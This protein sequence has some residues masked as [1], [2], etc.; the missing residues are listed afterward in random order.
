[1]KTLIGAAVIAGALVF[2]GPAAINSAVAA[3]PQTR[4]QTAGTSGATDFSAQR[5][6]RRTYGYGYRP[7]VRPYDPPT[8]YARPSYYRPYPYNVSAPFPLGL[9]FGPYW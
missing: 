9:G 3:S 2:A 6:Y 4:G 1:M 7:H 8:Y 5:Y